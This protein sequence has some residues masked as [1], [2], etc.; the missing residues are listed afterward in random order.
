MSM[1][2]LSSLRSQ[3]NGVEDKDLPKF[4]RDQIDGLAG[5]V[6]RLTKGRSR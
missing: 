4:V 1:S 5:E 3:W 6:D 2:N